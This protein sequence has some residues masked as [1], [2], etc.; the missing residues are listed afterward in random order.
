MSCPQ[1]RIPMDYKYL[2]IIIYHVEE[3]GRIHTLKYINGH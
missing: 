2:P 3:E 1:G